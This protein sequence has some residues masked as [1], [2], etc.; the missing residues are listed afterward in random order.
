MHTAFGRMI[1]EPPVMAASNFG[2]WS[3][4]FI[5]L[6]AAP[7]VRLRPVLERRL[8][9]L[10]GG[11]QFWPML[12]G[13]CLALLKRL[14]ERLPAPSDDQRQQIAALRD[15]ITELAAPT[16]GVAPRAGDARQDALTAELLARVYAEPD[17]IE[18]RMV[19][20]DAL[21]SAGDPRGE[22]VQL[23]LARDVADPPSKRERQ[24]LDQHGLTWLGPLAAVIERKTVR[25]EHGFVCRAEVLFDSETERAAISDPAWA[26]VRELDCDDV[27]LLTHPNLRALRRAG[28]FGF[29]QLRQLCDHDGAPSGLRSLGPIFVDQL[30]PFEIDHL[31]AARAPW[32]ANVSE[33]WLHLDDHGLSRHPNAYTW[34]FETPLGQRLTCFRLSGFPLNRDHESHAD[35]TVWLQ[36]MRSWPQ[37]ERVRLDVFSV[38]LEFVRE[39]A[40][41]KLRV[42][43]EDG[44]K[45]SDYRIADVCALL[46]EIGAQ[47][48]AIEF[49]SHAPDPLARETLTNL[50]KAAGFGE[51]DH[52]HAP[53]LDPGVGYANWRMRRGLVVRQ[54]RSARRLVRSRKQANAPVPRRVQTRAIYQP[55]ESTPWFGFRDG[56]DGARLRE[57]KWIEYSIDGRELWVLGD[58][59]TGLSAGDLQPRWR[60]AE[61]RGA[62]VTSVALDRA[63][64]RLWI[65]SGNGLTV[66]WDLESRH[67]L[68]R[69][70][71]HRSV[72]SAVAT[73][74]GRDLL[75]SGDHDGKLH[76][77]AYTPSDDGQAAVMIP[78]ASAS[79]EHGATAIDVD[80]GGDTLALRGRSGQISLR[81]VDELGR[82]RVIGDVGHGSAVLRWAP[83]GD[84]LVAAGADGG[85]VIWDADGTELTRVGLHAGMIRS[86]CWTPDGR[87][88]VT[89]GDCVRV[90]DRETGAE[91]LRID[92]GPAR[93]SGLAVSP[94]GQV[95]AVSAFGRVSC[96]SLADGRALG[97]FSGA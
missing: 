72:V 40:R 65:G 77:W 29:A 74:P 49:V 96:W 4:M 85:L 91:L 61:Q 30:P 93:I 58:C 12:N 70:R 67:T 37:L 34:L 64:A 14:P 48:D 94:D 15:C 16:T 43:S 17:V 41:T 27:E 79:L 63:R 66:L 28:G 76:A 73:V 9:R 13:R 6:K 90:S 42:R 19:W 8:E 23:Q 68:A 3:R 20:A 84:H 45:P 82:C 21:I 26:T 32:L 71:F 50:A 57:G 80:P 33:V 86:L 75:I 83:E 5:M 52:V 36:A 95:L 7:D 89:A 31:R 46:G 11:S 38:S 69:A 39:G 92:P 47:F 88:L 55:V 53:D 10:G 18:H 2:I 54:Q 1:T 97:G 78:R 22:F 25:Y 62:Y 35:A 60:L 59:V 56:I 81:A 44:R 87:A 24:L 51:Y